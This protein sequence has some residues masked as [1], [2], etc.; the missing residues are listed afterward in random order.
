MKSWQS[1]EEHKVLRTYNEDY[2]CK[3]E[4]Y[5]LADKTDPFHIQWYRKKGDSKVCGH[6]QLP[7]NYET[8]QTCSYCKEGYKGN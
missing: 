6:N 8:D 5:K 4:F 1:L 7:L 2:L 3:I